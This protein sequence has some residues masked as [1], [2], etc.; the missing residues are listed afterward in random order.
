MAD[1]PDNLVLVHLREIRAEMKDIR[2]KLGEHD[3]HFEALKKRVDE[4]F[5]TAT[6]GVGLAVMANRKLDLA[7]DDHEQ[8]IAALEQ[9]RVS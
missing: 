2:A 1:E 7:I 4:L 6:F 3:T 9:D 8:R 5:E